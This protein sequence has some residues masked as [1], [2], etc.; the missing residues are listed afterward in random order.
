MQVKDVNRGEKV[1]RLL[2][3][4][5]STAINKLQK[6][7]IWNLLVQ[8]GQTKCYVC[9]KEMTRETF[10]IEHIISWLNSDNP[11]ENFWNLDN[12]AFS[13]SV[14]NKPYNTTREVRHGT[15]VGYNYHGCRCELCTKAMR[16][17]QR[18]Y[19]NLQ[20]AKQEKTE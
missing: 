13:H 19:R 15:Q 17:Y 7:I 12:I 18:R 16:E 14:C 11:K 6:D 9:G 2:G 8:L 10:T 20:K 1:K 5:H 3:M 4:A